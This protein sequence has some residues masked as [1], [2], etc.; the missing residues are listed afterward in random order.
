MLIDT[1]GRK[2][3]Y[4]RVSVT[5]RCN[6][7]CLYCM[8]REVVPL[9]GHRD[10]LSF[11]EIETIV[12]AAVELGVRKVRLTGGEPL[13]RK[14]FPKLVVKLASL[15]RL[16]DLAMTTNGVLFAPLA[17]KLKQAGLKRVNISLDTLKPE[18]FREMSGSGDWAG[19][20]EAVEAAVKHRYQRVKLNV[21]VI[22]G[23]NDDEAG[24]F[25]RFAMEKGVHL[26]FIELMPLGND[27]WSPDRALAGDE[28]R[29]RVEREVSLSPLPQDG[30]ATEYQ[31][32]G[33]PSTV[34]FIN[35]LSQPFCRTCNRLRLTADGFLR[36]CLA[37]QSEINLREP[38]RHGMSGPALRRLF[39]EALRL[40]GQGHR[41][42]GG[43]QESNRLMAEIGG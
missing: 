22:A 28:L 6:L 5:D 31:I 23:Y 13:L 33:S 1:H 26:R 14:D 29:K 18:R 42:N 15:Q 34:G 24:D 38:V 17:G 19:V 32:K 9:R 39:Y 36:P 20:I 7:R 25:V 41:F 37:G 27:F 43:R 40:K 16:D 2:I 12:R 8:P 30:V 11:E 21:V 4:L 10:M 3:T 35:P